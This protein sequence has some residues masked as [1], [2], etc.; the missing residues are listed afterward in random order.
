M[1]P[2]D[3]KRALVVDDEPCTRP[4]LREALEAVGMEVAEAVDGADAIHK[5]LE[6]HFDLAT[7]DIMMPNV[8]GLDAIRAMR[9][10]DPTYRIIVVSST[11]DDQHRKAIRELG[12][13]QLIPKPV[14]FA[15]LHEAVRVALTDPQPSGE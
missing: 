6:T 2:F 4:L 12:V 10:V 8:N 1:K 11:I 13:P 7:M 5:S 15:E 9:M 14:G 3:G